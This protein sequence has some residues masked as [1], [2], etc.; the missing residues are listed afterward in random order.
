VDQPVYIVM[1]LGNPGPD[2]EETR[3]NAGFRIVR[4][5]ATELGLRF[6][7]PFLHKVLI[8]SCPLERL[9]LLPEANGMVF[10]KGTLLFV[11]P[12]TY[13]NNSGDIL[14]WLIRRYAKGKELPPPL[15]LVD[16]MDL[17]PGNLRIKKKGGTAG[18]NGLKSVHAILDDTFYPLYIGIG[19]P[20]PGFSV[21]D[22]VLGIPDLDDKRAFA[23]I[24]RK[25]F[26][27]L[28]CLYTAGIDVAMQ[29]TN[30]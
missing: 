5:L 27:A 29:V 14:P 28:C 22:W 8:A 24:T 20:A 17:A 30:S 18:H 26:K 16:Q 11:L 19:R 15:V 3:H 4:A 21:V 12:L 9:S 23:L 13:M 7:K 6:S 10:G 25:A 2:F 1:G